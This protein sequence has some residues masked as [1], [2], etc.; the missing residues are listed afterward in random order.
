MNP[1][2]E[3]LQDKLD[4]RLLSFIIGAGFSKNLHNDF[5]SWAELLGDLVKELYHDEIETAYVAQSENKRDYQDFCKE[6]V[7]KIIKRDGYLKIA[8]DYITRCGYREC[9]DDYIEKHT[10]YLVRTN[11]GFELHRDGMPIAKQ[12]SLDLRVHRALFSLNVQDIYTF[13]Y[14]NLLELTSDADQEEALQQKRRDIQ[15]ELAKF[16]QLVIQYKEKR[17]ALKEEKTTKLI[18]EECQTQSSDNSA[19]DALK[20]FYEQHI[21]RYLSVSGDSS[22]DAID[23]AIEE[24]RMEYHSSM[25]QLDTK[26]KQL[27]H[28]VNQSWDISLSSGRKNIYKLHGDLRIDKSHPYGFDNDINHHYIICR[29]DYDTYTTRHEAFVNLMKI[30]LLKG[31]VCVVGF[32]GDDPNFLNWMSWVRTILQKR[33]DPDSVDN[34]VFFIDATG[35]GLPSD[36]RQLFRNNF[37]QYVSLENI[38]Q[39]GNATANLLCFFDELKDHSGDYKVLLNE[40]TK[41]HDTDAISRLGQWRTHYY[42]PR[43]DGGLNG[44]YRREILSNYSKSAPLTD[45]RVREFIIVLTG[46]RLFIHNVIGEDWDKAEIFDSDTRN[47]IDLLEIRE[48]IVENRPAQIDINRGDAFYYER[49]LQLLFAFE[50]GQAYDL[51]RQWSPRGF[52]QVRRL[53]MLSIFKLPE[54]EKVNVVIFNKHSYDSLQEYIYALNILPNIRGVYT[55]RKG[56]GMTAHGDVGPIIE[57]LIERYPNLHELH[58]DIKLFKKD[59]LQNDDTTI[60]AYGSNYWSYTFDRMDKKK[61][62]SLQLFQTFIELGLPMNGRLM[63]Y[64]DVKIWYAAFKKLYKE[65]PYPCL[66]FS[67]QYGLNKQF[68]KRVAQDYAYSSELRTML[69]DLLNKL[70]QA[71]RSDKTPRNV[72]EGIL[73]VCTFWLQ[74]VDSAIWKDAFRYIIGRCNLQSTDINRARLNPIYD[75]IETGLQMSKDTR[76]KQKVCLACLRKQLAIDHVDNSLII[77]SCRGLKGIDSAIGIQIDH[78]LKVCSESAQFFVLENLKKYMNRSQRDRLR[79]VMRSHDYTQERDVIMFELATRYLSQKNSDLHT[80]LKSAILESS[81]LWCTGIKDDGVITGGQHYI[82]LSHL[83]K[84]RWTK[85]EIG[86]IYKKLTKA[87]HAIDSQQER[88]LPF[89]LLDWRRLLLEMIVFLNLY[90]EILCGNS[91][92]NEIH[93]LVDK[94]YRKELGAKFLVEALTSS[95]EQIVRYGIEQMVYDIHMGRIK[96][97]M[98]EY[99]IVTNRILMHMPAGLNSCFTHYVW[100][101]AKYSSKFPKSIFLPISIKIMESYQCYF[102]D[103]R[104]WDIDTAM[105]KIESALVGLYKTCRKWGYSNSFWEHYVPRFDNVS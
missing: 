59:L 10:P 42:L 26:C 33:N 76:L 66:Y 99:Q 38:Y 32:S 7:A 88:S 90:Q 45:D 49:I 98:T 14:D 60:K 28:K 68:M 13:N 70:L 47:T 86:S 73:H 19:M 29:E 75:F 92:Y 81:Q 41:S 74:C 9:I 82:R 95:D 89:P 58:E 34:H 72:S 40:A 80:N 55:Q 27:Y 94:L 91:D 67:L 71:Y 56:G 103:S 37:I 53:A 52:W 16:E 61:L 1:Y 5:P 22:W 69:P 102:D 35:T 44:E 36:K 93:E 11:D 8:S 51:L 21:E 6:K 43:L 79:E 84:L 54:R 64:L 12:E 46:E 78:L 77:A 4:D 83:Q 85:E 30:S 17:S 31:S 65:Y 100:C 18:S 96:S 50:Y 2:I 97:N 62:R 101:L 3:H 20:R 39:K 105:D 87:V 57:K 24:K 15:R 48:Q 104:P 23:S 25:D 63:N